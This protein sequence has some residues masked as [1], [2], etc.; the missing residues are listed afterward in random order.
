MG[1]QMP[2]TGALKAEQIALIKAWIDQGAE[3][4]DAV[5]GE[6][7]PP[8]PDPTAQKLIDALR[9]GNRT[10]FRQAV[11]QAPSLGAAKGK[12][13]TTP[14]MEAVLYGSVDDMRQ[15]LDRRRRC[16]RA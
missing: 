7:P 6:T 13:G 8:P 5:S 16:Q 12:S 4:P 1:S 2:P 9:A 10:A 3:W 11:A 15:L 14:L